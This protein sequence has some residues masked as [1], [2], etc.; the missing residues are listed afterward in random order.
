MRR[1]VLSVV[2]MCTA[3]AVTLHAQP[4]RFEVAAGVVAGGP[5]RFG[6]EYAALSG[7]M[8]FARASAVTFGIEASALLRVSA[9]AV[10]ACL[11]RPGWGCDSRELGHVAQAAL[12]ALLGSRDGRGTYM[13]AAAGGW[14]SR[15]AEGSFRGAATSTARPYGGVAEIGVGT[16]LPFGDRRTGAEFRFGYYGTGVPDVSRMQ[17]A[18]VNTARIAVTRRW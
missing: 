8:R 14:V 18:A 13:L 1:S 7:G 17:V 6:S 11:D 12:F 2:A 4:P 16:S 15:W 10:I 5:A 9:P 3:S